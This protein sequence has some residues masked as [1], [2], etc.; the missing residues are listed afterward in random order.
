MSNDEI[1]I[2]TAW[3][4]SRLGDV[5]DVSGGLTKNSKRDSLPDKY[6][7]LR[8]ANVYANELR[9]DDVAEIGI[10]QSELD[11]VLLQ[12]G[13]LLVVEGNGSL[14]HIGRVAVWN[15]AINP[16]LHQNHLIKV[17]LPEQIRSTFALYWLLSANGRDD[18]VRVASSTSGLHTLSLSKVAVLR[19]PVA[20]LDEQARIVEAIE[21]YFTRLDDAVA[22]L[23]RVEC[24]LKRYRASVLKSAVE[25]RLVPTEAELARQEGRDHEPAD[26][27]LQRILEERRRRW[28]E[29]ELAKM[30][31]KGKPPK[32][33]KWKAKYKEPAAPDTANLPELPEGWCWATVEQLASPEP[34]S[35]QSGPFGSSLRH[36]EF[37]E[38]GKLVVGIDNVQDGHFS[39][40][41][42]NRIS[43]TKYADLERFTA[44]PGDVLVTVMATI[45]RTCVL[46]EE[47]EPAIITKH[48]YRVSVNR[49]FILPRYLHI[50]LWGGPIVREQMFGQVQGQTRPGLNGSIIKGLKI[51]VPPLREQ[52]HILDETD[53]LL[54][55]G[56]AATQEIE[57]TARRCHRLRQ[58]ILKWAFE[59]KLADQNPD[60]EPA[61]VLLERIKA[62]RETAQPAKKP[63]RTRRRKPGR[64]KASQP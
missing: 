58:A 29:A 46:P 47:L 60:D 10:K 15:G 43:E 50:C 24:N 61:S 48:V 11:R 36:S 7:Y 18:I 49:N 38:S 13:D 4:W 21:S 40:G 34:R 39:M 23:E 35:I 28:Q 17:R 51:P 9:L 31:A 59:G 19:V 53:H 62:E 1:A 64:K 2:P 45:G 14:E 44:R 25:G 56:S 37:T 30:E 63:A 20:P 6:P 22:T 52:A 32:D 16:C 41:S 12:P 8:V 57:G 27:L 3:E 5:G 55:V 54:S 42:E 33:D 26:V